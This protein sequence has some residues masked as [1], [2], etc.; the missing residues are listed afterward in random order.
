MRILRCSIASMALA[1]ASLA[2]SL[3]ACAPAGSADGEP[4][5]TRCQEPRPEL[6]TM[7]YRPVCGY[8]T[9]DASCVDPDCDGATW[10]TYS[11]ACGACSDRAV[12]GF[13]PGACETPEPRG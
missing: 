1:I 9:P 11:N 4:A 10:K 5:V 7:D 8:R 12:H 3:A 2:L 13:R 6:C